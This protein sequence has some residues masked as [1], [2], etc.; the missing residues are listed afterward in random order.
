MIYLYWYIGI[1]VAILVI[2][3]ISEEWGSR[4]E[5]K[6]VR[7][8]QDAMN[9]ERTKL[10]YRILSNYLAPVLAAV[11][12]IFVW[13]AVLYMKINDMRNKEV[14]EIYKKMEAKVFKVAKADLL[15][16]KSVAQIES[17]E[18]VVDPLAAV[19]PLPFGHFNKR[20]VDFLAQ[21]LP[22]DELWS[23]KS[24]WDA[25]WGLRPEIRIGYTLVRDGAPEAYI[26]TARIPVN[27]DGY[28]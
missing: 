16:Q 3:F 24:R 23:F 11:L 7:D 17:A 1:G 25:D 26:L 2:G 20:W 18:I 10:S 12:V 5:S 15:E 14:D 27:K 6:F 8:I 19:P 28:K 22:G 9:P 21:M 4:P 13:P